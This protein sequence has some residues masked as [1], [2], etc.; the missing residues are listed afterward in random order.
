MTHLELSAQLKQVAI[1]LRKTAGSQV[2]IVALSQKPTQAILKATEYLE[3]AKNPEVRAKMQQYLDHVDPD[4]A[5]ELKY[6]CSNRLYNSE[7]E[8][9]EAIADYLKVFNPWLDVL[10][11]K[12]SAADFQIVPAQ[13]LPL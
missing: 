1:K 13:Q 10:N 2:R 8:A 11:M 12:M 3:N 5:N 9:R 4:A 7:T 6:L